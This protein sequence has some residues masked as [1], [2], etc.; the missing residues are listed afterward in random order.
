MKVSYQW[1]QEISG[2]EADLDSLINK[3]TN[4]GLKLEDRQPVADDV[5]LDLEITVN[6]PDCLSH[7]GVAREIITAFSLPPLKQPEIHPVSP[8][9]VRGTEGSYDRLKIILDDPDLCARYCG[10]LLTGVKV[11]PS[12]DWMKQRLEVCGIRGINNVVDVTNFVMLELGQPL[13]A[14]DYDK[15]AGGTIRVRRA[16]NE[17]LLMIDG[18]ERLLTESMLTIADGEKAQAVGGVMGGQDSEV[19]ERTT[20]VLLESAYFMP[21]TIRQTRRAF[22]LSTDASYRFERG[23]DSM[24]Q[25]VAIRRTA[26]LLE[27]IAGAKV[28]PVLDVNVLDVPQRQ[29]ELRPERLQRI[30]GESIDQ[31]FLER[32]LISLGFIKEGKKSW[33]VPSFRVDIAREIDLIEEVAR[34]FGYNNFPSTLPEGGIKYQEDYPAYWLERAI[35]QFLQ[36]ARVDEAS[37]LSFV[38][39]TSAYAPIVKRIRIKNPISPIWDELR[40]SLIPGLLGSIERNLRYRSQEVRLF[41]IGR[42]FQEDRSEKVMVGIAIIGDYQDLKGILE[43]ALAALQYPKPV[44]QSGRILLSDLD[45]GYIRPEVV[46]GNSVQTCELSLTDLIQI[47]KIKTTYKPIIVYPQ[48]ERDVTFVIDERVHYSWMLETVKRCEIPQLRSFKLIDRYKGKNAPP[49]KV[50]LTFRI[51]FQSENRTLLSAEVDA[52]YAKIVAEFAKVFGAELRK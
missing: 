27:Q 30:L 23:V 11:G 38:D 16:R 2:V 37:T 43:G 4:I 15:L 13:H 14:F 18:K 47:P 12:P 6:R 31:E 3:L 20:N 19:S 33:I 8:I 44:I 21:K 36:S 41:E 35:S 1:L 25:D 32:I 52:L 7:Y 5:S 24:M 46:E 34:H 39:A 26:L 10:Q 45:L 9:Q 50:N 42:I 51:V 29:I 40:T 17:K 49:G 22:D 28:H 48:V